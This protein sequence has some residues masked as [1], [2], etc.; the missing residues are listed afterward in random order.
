MM[1]KALDKLWQPTFDK[2]QRTQCWQRIMFHLCID[3]S[4][5]HKALLGKCIHI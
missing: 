5:P 1:T 2:R 4:V 3:V